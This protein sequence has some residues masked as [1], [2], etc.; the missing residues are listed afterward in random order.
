MN[1]GNSQSQHGYNVGGYEKKQYQ[2]VVESQQKANELVLKNPMN[3]K[4]CP[5]RFRNQEL[6][7]WALRKNPMCIGYIPVEKLTQDHCDWAVKQNYMAHKF[8]DISFKTEEMLFYV[9]SNA[10][11]EIFNMPSHLVSLRM[12]K[13]ALSLNGSIYRDLPNEVKSKELEEI[14]MRAE[15]QP[16]K[17]Q[18][19]VNPYATK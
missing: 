13:K 5:Y 17:R 14:A 1:W 2:V 8:V 18:I 10:P 9:V 3:L 7:D 19:Y 6:C 16:H 4:Y 12:V 11:L 15:H